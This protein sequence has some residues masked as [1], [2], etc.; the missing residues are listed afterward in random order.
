MADG[1]FI[2]KVLQASFS[3]RQWPDVVKNIL[4]FFV[5]KPYSNLN[6]K[7]PPFR[8]ASALVSTAASLLCKLAEKKR[9]SL[10]FFD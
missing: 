6:T 5:T 2:I 9:N 10:R 1:K 4:H 8:E 7:K 3:D